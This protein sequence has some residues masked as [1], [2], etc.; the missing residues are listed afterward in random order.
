MRSSTQKPRDML[1]LHPA[2]AQLHVVDRRWKDLPAWARLASEWRLYRQAA[3]PALRPDRAPDGSSARR[4]A[5]A[6]ARACATQW[7]PTWRARRVP[8]SA[9]LRIS[10]RS[11]HRD[12]PPGRAESRYPA[13]DRDPARRCRA[14]PGARSGRGG[15]ACRRCAACRTRP[16]GRTL[17][18]FSSGF[19]LAVQVLAGG[20]RSGAHR[21]ARGARRSSDPDRGAGRQGNGV[22]RSNPRTCAHAIH[23]FV[24]KAHA[25]AARRPRRVARGSSSAWIRR[26]CTS[27]RRCST[28]VVALFGPSSDVEWG[29]WRV[30]HR[31]VASTAH[32]CRPCG[33]DGCGGGKVSECISR[34]PLD[35]VLQAADALLAQ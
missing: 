4:L 28:P 1:E 13:Q 31:V 29:P 2:L 22:H 25:Q 24:G 19:S 20:S 35:S 34:L 33:N 7:L 3:R 23:G 15:R 30:A 16:H 12:A 26:R 5:R 6:R 8:G 17:R 27:P 9:A 14:G 32:R 21:C 11:R 10:F 18:P